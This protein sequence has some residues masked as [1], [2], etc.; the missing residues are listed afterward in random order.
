MRLIAAAVTL[1]RH[2]DVFAQACRVDQ[3]NLVDIT[4]RILGD[5]GDAEDVLQDANQTLGWKRKL[6]ACTSIELSRC[7]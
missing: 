1:H 4:F 3:A 2:D 7:G 6:Q 5:I